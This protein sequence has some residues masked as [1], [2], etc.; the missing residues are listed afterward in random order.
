MTEQ[1]DCILPEIK[2]ALGQQRIFTAH[3]QWSQDK[4]ANQG[5]LI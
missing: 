1:L 5:S 3:I 4:H 2:V